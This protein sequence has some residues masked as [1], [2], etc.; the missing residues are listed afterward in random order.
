MKEARVAAAA[1]VVYNTSC[2]DSVTCKG[3]EQVAR[4]GM[5]ILIFDN[6]T[7]DY[8]NREYCEG[9]NWVYLGGRGNLGISKAYNS[10][11][12][13]LKQQGT[14]GLLCLF[15]DDTFVG[16]RYFEALEQAASQS[17]KGIFAPLIWSAGRLMSPSRIT[18]GHKVRLFEN[19]QQALGYQGDDLT[20]INSCMAV[21]LKLFDSYRYDENI[22]LDGVDHHFLRQMSQR[23]H[24]ICVFDY[25][26]DHQFSGDSKPAFDGAVSRFQIY[27][28]DYAYILRNDQFAYWK[29]VGKRALHLT[30]QYKSSAFLKILFQK[31]LK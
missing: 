18:P 12:S 2:K 4:P 13:Y 24:G 25:R 29:L 16:E 1:V 7:R 28:K 20:A 10:C 31:W 30:L 14:E 9:R 15:D 5:R 11:I 21:D 27:A 23:G 6:S 19:E 17:D 22:F 8:G 26:C 3:L